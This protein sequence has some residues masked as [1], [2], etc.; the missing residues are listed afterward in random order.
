MLHSLSHSPEHPEASDTE[1]PF[2]GKSRR[3]RERLALRMPVRIYCRESADLDWTELTR[4]HDVTPFGARFSLTRPTEPGRLLHLTLPL[5]RTLRCYDYAEEQ[6]RIW[7]LVRHVKMIAADAREA[8]SFIVGVAFVGKLPPA[9]F[10]ANPTLLYDVAPASVANS[11]WTIQGKAK[12]TVASTRSDDTRLNMPIE[13]SAEIL[14][15]A[16]AVAARQETVTENISRRGAAIFATEKVERGTYV[17]LKSRQ[18]QLSVLAVV[19][20][21]RGG[22]DGILRLH[23]EF[24]DRQWPLEGV[25]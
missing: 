7:S 25:E 22:A 4:L 20:A 6:Y 10:E 14:D 23:L 8:P 16:G 3:R 17:V 15:Q 1:M 13:V 5:P 11:L 9:S 21:C 12:V 18:S 2:K 19:R 24:V